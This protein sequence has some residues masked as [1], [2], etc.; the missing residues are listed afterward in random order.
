MRVAVRTT[1]HLP[2]SSPCTGAYDTTLAEIM[3]NFWIP[4]E[5][6]PALPAVLPPATVQVPH[7]HS[8]H[9]VPGRGAM[10]QF[11]YIVAALLLP[12]RDFFAICDSHVLD[13]R[14]SGGFDRIREHAACFYVLFFGC[15]GT[16]S[17]FSSRVGRR[18]IIKNCTWS[19]VM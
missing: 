12:C 2:S 13:E 9:C 11:I 6:S 8:I 7:F 19:V 5:P 1:S 17:H 16:L 15:E 18:I 10:V 14:V 3:L 4:G